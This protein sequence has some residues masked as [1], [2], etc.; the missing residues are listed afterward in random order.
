MLVLV[1][2][3]N[4]PTYAIPLVCCFSLLIFSVRGTRF[5]LAALCSAF[6]LIRYRYDRLMVPATVPV[7]LLQFELEHFEIPCDISTLGNSIRLS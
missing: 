5:S 3:A 6:F 7:S 2:A 4:S 1:I